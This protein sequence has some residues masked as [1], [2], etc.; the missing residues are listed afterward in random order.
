M[1]KSQLSGDTEVFKMLKT[2]DNELF[3]E[4]RKGVN[5]QLKPVVAPIEAEINS[6]V[7][8]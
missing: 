3:K 4:L 1:K 6:S 5:S 7:T 2:Y 8:N